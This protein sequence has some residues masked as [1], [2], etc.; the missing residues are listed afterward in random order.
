MI[1]KYVIFNS[2]SIG[3]QRFPVAV[4]NTRD[5]AEEIASHLFSYSDEQL[6]ENVVA[7]MLIAS[8]RKS[9]GEGNA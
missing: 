7:V 2:V 4:A 6:D 1:Y 9:N 3:G 5:E 8:N